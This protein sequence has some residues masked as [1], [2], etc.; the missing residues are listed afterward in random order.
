MA[1]YATLACPIGFLSPTITIASLERKGGHQLT[2]QKCLPKVQYKEWI[3]L[4]PSPTS[5]S[6]FWGNCDLMQKQSLRERILFAPIR[7]SS[8]KVCSLHTKFFIFIKVFTF[9]FS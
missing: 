9:S 1:T 5:I 3:L 7:L 6:F 2:Y 8:I 4:K